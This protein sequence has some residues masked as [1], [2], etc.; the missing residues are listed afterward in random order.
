MEE[1]GF[2][3]ANSIHDGDDWRSVT[4]QEIELQQAPSL[5]DVTWADDL[6]LLQAHEDCRALIRRTTLVG[7]L[8]SDLRSWRGLHLNYKAGKTECLLRLKGKGTRALR[9]EPFNTD[10]PCLRLPS[11][12]HEDLFVRIVANYK[13]LA[14]NT[15]HNGKF[16]NA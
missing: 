7:G 9:L 2:V 3:T 10:S 15:N 4:C 16:A 11:T 5:I 6:V 12:L 8:L 1:A 13:H 14:S